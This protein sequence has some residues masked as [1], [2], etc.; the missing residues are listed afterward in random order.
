MSG[1]EHI[2]ASPVI[3]PTGPPIVKGEVVQVKLMGGDLAIPVI[4]VLSIIDLSAHLMIVSDKE[5]KLTASGPG[6]HRNTMSDLPP[7]VTY[8]DR[9]SGSWGWVCPPVSRRYRW[10]IAFR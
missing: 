10:S 1:D 6:P 7:I 8:V 2:V 5:A 4:D 3:E 9:S